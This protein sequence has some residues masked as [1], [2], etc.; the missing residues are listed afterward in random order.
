MTATQVVVPDS[1][2]TLTDSAS[3][4]KFAMD[5]FAGGHFQIVE[6]DVISI[7]WYACPTIGGTFKA[8][9]DP[10]TGEAITQTVATTGDY[11]IP[12]DLNGRGFL[13]PRCATGTSGTMILG[14][15]TN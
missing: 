12:Y 2:L 8:A 9:I 11:V 1:A 5:G 10:T 6:G 3:S 4:A 7:E 13:Q 15:K 14:K